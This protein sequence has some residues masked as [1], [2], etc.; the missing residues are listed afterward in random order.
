ML[1][2]G[3]YFLR[4]WQQQ[5][6]NFLEV[7]F[8]KGS[9]HLLIMAVL[10]N[11]S[12]CHTVLLTAPGF[13]FAKIASCRWFCLCRVLRV[14]RTQPTLKT[15]ETVFQSRACAAA[16]MTV[17]TVQAESAFHLM[18]RVLFHCMLNMHES[19]AWGLELLTLVK[20]L[21]PWQATQQESTTKTPKS[22]CMCALQIWVH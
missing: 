2:V 5:N 22:H 10:D 1:V 18:Q 19:A 15:E 20:S 16:A 9:M 4:L 12:L 7:N 21:D 11:F 14:Y 3:N 8:S 17:Y 6:S 13:K